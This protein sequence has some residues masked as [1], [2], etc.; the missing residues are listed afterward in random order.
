MLLTFLLFAL[1][2]FAYFCECRTRFNVFFLI[3]LSV[4]LFA[5]F[6]LG[7]WNEFKYNSGKKRRN[8]QRKTE[9]KKSGQTF[10]KTWML[11]L[12]FCSENGH[13][14]PSTRQKLQC[15]Y[16]TMRTSKSVYFVKDKD[17]IQWPKR[18]SLDETVRFH[19][20]ISPFPPSRMWTTT[21]TTGNQ[22]QMTLA[23]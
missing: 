10:H 9:S 13:G 2:I 5:F 19:S 15:I 6:V 4:Q 20:P 11:Y 17:K 1:V 12:I 8:S 18:F 7:P 21:A 16:N 22:L 23:A 3:T 14:A